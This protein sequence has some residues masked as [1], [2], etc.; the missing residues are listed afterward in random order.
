MTSLRLYLLRHATAVRGGPHLKDFDRP[1]AEAG[2]AQAEQLAGIVVQNGYAPARIVCSTAQRARQT[3]EPLLQHFPDDTDIELTRRSYEADVEALLAEVR[4]S[5]DGIGSLLLVGHNPA[6]EELAHLLVGNGD[7]DA[8]ARL[9][10]GF[11]TAALAVIDIAVAGWDAVRPRQ[12]RLAAF[13]TPGK[14]SPTRF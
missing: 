10:G 12:G 2:R 4:S 3:L 13:H 14:P 5:G 7:G 9:A 8:T 6:T 1:L 11:P